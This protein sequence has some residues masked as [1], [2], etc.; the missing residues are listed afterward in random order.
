L[1]QDEESIA[2]NAVELL[3]VMM[4]NNKRLLLK[5]QVEYLIKSSDFFM[6]DRGCQLLVPLLLELMARQNNNEEVWSSA[7]AACTC[8]TLVSE[9]ISD[10]ILT[11][12]FPFIHTFITFEDWRQRE[13][14]FYA[15]DAFWMACHTR[16]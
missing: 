13:A 12:V 7:K 2:I 14:V 5:S 4:E 6:L 10:E 8:L 3:S 11:L 16:V 1:L 9:L 15:F